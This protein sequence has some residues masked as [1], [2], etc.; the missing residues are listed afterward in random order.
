M[1]WSIAK[2]AVDFFL[3]NSICDERSEPIVIDFMGGE[4]F[5]EIDLIDRICDYFLAQFRRMNHPWRRNYLFSILSNGTLY[6][7]RRVQE[8][9]QSLQ[10][11]EYC[12]DI[13]KAM[14]GMHC[15]RWVQVL[16]GG[17]H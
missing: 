2:S 5:L 15:I 3:D 14:L 7:D 4:P 12:V 6:G 16:S 9:I 11:F 8:F 17:R 1:T 13:R 10:S